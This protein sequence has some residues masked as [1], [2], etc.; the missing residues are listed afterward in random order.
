M[1]T[2]K[3]FPTCEYCGR[4]C[5]FKVAASAVVDAQKDFV[6]TVLTRVQAGDIEE[7]TQLTMEKA[8]DTLNQ[9]FDPMS[10]DQRGLAY[11]ILAHIVDK[12]NLDE[13]EELR[14]KTMRSVKGSLVKLLKNAA[15]L[16]NESS[17]I[18]T[19]DS[20]DAGLDQA[21]LRER[22]AQLRAEKR[23]TTRKSALDSGIPGEQPIGEQI[24]DWLRSDSK[25]MEVVKG[26]K[27]VAGGI[28]LTYD[29]ETEG[30]IEAV[31]IQY[32]QKSFNLGD[33]MTHLTKLRL[34]TSYN[35]KYGQDLVMG[36]GEKRGN[37]I[38]AKSFFGGIPKDEGEILQALREVDRKDATQQDRLTLIL[39][40][41]RSLRRSIKKLPL[42]SD[43]PARVPDI[44]VPIKLRHY[45]DRVQIICT[46]FFDPGTKPRKI[47]LDVIET[48]AEDLDN[49]FDI[50]ENL[51]T[52]TA[53]ETSLFEVN[54]SKAPKQSFHFISTGGDINVETCPNCGRPFP[55]PDA[56]YRRC[57]HCLFKLM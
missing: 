10:M 3:Q 28:V 48:L 22:R 7:A 23:S 6:N 55:D 36:F 4:V 32:A 20:S 19:D 49:L 46:C 27:K 34:L 37:K 26:L 13:D 53:G 52:T 24:L 16:P 47:F 42:D 11:C 9:K 41:D 56:E 51:R 29:P 33:G 1:S 40:N 17:S 25:F 8:A 30:Y 35:V 38:V 54:V 21:S 14:K 45:K 12:L 43:F 50:D 39:N 57:P 5:E 15:A 18:D 31:K 44:R 2:I